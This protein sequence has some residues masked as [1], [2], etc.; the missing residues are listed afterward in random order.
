MTVALTVLKSVEKP[1]LRK[2]VSY[3]LKIMQLE[4]AL[5]AANLTQHVDL[6]YWQ[7]LSGGSILQAYYWLAS[8]RIEHGRVYVRAGCISSEQRRD[9]AAALTNEGLPRFIAWVRSLVA[10]PTNS[11]ILQKKPFFDATYRADG[12]RVQH[13]PSQ[14]IETIRQES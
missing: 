4:T 14:L 2:G 10:Q 1:K 11:P 6:R 7:P 12:L 13:T 5:V 3:A 9:A 8:E